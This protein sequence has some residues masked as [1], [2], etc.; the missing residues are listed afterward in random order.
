[1]DGFQDMKTIS[2]RRLNRST[3]K[4]SKKSNRSRLFFSVPRRNSGLVTGGLVLLVFFPD[5]YQ[6]R[7]GEVH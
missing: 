3:K 2:Q 5:P 4:R 7:V 1:M 6:R